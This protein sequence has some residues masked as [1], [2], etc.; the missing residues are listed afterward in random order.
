VTR[1]NAGFVL[2]VSLRALACSSQPSES[3]KSPSEQ[4]QD[5]VSRYCSK[6]V[7]CAASTDRADFTDTCAFSFQVY[8]PCAQVTFVAADSQRCLDAIDAIPCS[9][10]EAG[11]FPATPTACQMLFGVD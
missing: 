8:L 7:A 10:V 3:D 11:G 9:S 4:C 6:A 1:Q 2:V 5:Y